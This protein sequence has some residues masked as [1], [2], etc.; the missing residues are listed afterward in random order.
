MRWVEFSPADTDRADTAARRRRQNAINKGLI[1]AR[2]LRADM[3]RKLTIE[4]DGARNELAGKLYLDP[5]F[6]HDVITG[7]L[8]NTPDLEDWI[9]VK[10][11]MRRDYRMPVPRETEGGHKDWAYLLVYGGEHPHYGIM[12]WCWGRE[13]MTIEATDPTYTGRTPAHF[14]RQDAT[15]MKK[16]EELFSLVRQRQKE[17]V[18]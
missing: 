15:F 6:W 1:P 14:I 8:Y 18:S 7:S 5:V 9:D 12:G 17:L 10:G 13:A 11:I 2:G 3:A 4:R 16:P